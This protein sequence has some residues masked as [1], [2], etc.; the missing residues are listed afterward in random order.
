MATERLET[1]GLIYKT[2]RETL[3]R[4]L[5]T[6]KPHNVRMHKNI[7]IYKTLLRT[8]VRTLLVINTNVRLI[9]RACTSA[10]LLPSPSHNSP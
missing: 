3:P 8:P 5:R 2:L 7:P 10:L 6:P 1:R 9:W 4:T